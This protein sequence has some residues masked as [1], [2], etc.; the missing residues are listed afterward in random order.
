MEVREDHPVAGVPEVERFALLLIKHLPDHK[1]ELQ[2]AL[3][4][5]A[6]AEY[7][8]P[9]EEEGPGEQPENE[10]DGLVEP[11]DQEALQAE[12][13]EQLRR[14]PEGLPDGGIDGATPRV[15]RRAIR[16]RT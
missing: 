8:V 9:P 3:D 11:F 1:K 5:F 13:I 2:A 7:P 16:R 6:S 10:T 12:A 15:E 14:H 4:E